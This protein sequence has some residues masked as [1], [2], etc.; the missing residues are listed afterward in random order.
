MF[1]V[2]LLADDPFTTYQWG[3]VTPLLQLDHVYHRSSVRGGPLSAEVSASGPENALWETLNWL[4]RPIE[5]RNEHGQLVW[6]GLVN[7]VRLTWAGLTIGATLDT[8]SNRI[9]VAYSYTDANGGSVRGTTAWAVNQSSIDRYGTKERLLSLGEGQAAGAL[10]RRTEELTNYASPRGVPSFGG[11]DLGATLLCVGWYETLTWQI[12][13]RLEGRIEFGESSNAEHSLGWGLTSAHIGFA[14]EAIHHRFAS[15]GALA[16][17]D[18][19]IVTGSASNN[20]TFTIKSAT[21]RE[22]TTYTA[23]TISFDAADDINDSANGL[24]FVETDS[25]VNVAGSAAN[26]RY[27]FVNE[28]GAGHLATDEA[29][30]GTITTAAAGPNIT[31]S[32]G[33]KVEVTEAITAEVPGA[34]VTLSLIG[35]RIAQ[36]FVV[37]D[38]I[39][40]TQVSI[41][42]GKI[43]SPTDNFQCEIWSNVSSAPGASLQAISV[44]GADLL[45]DSQPWRWITFT[46]LALSAGTY[47]LVVR[48]SGTVDALNYYSL[49]MTD[50]ANGTC[51]A[52]NGAAW[53]AHPR[54]LYLPYRVWGTESSEAQITRIISD[55]GQFI[56][57]VDGVAT[58]INTNQYRDG[59]MTAYDEIEKLLDLGSSAGKRLLATVTPA[60]MLR[61][62]EEPAKST[63]GDRLQPDGT[64]RNI[65]SGR[66]QRGLLPTG[67]WLVVDG[68]PSSINA[69]LDLSPLFVDEAGW[70]ATDPDI[71]EIQP[72]AA[73]VDL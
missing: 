61:I 53:V 1:A 41:P 27:H 42:I 22:Q 15:L 24:G 57:G 62:Y 36:S 63:D 31:L 37:T 58:G 8:M 56:A 69:Q 28:A 71:F 54:A 16:V 19:V 35:V 70:R 14:A 12:F 55:A 33:H 52:W 43:G 46:G 67:E 65:A 3:I 32:A 11:G 50:V 66:R 60:R 44:A 26:S 23:T 45:A 49:G 9:A 59:D 51:L 4:R 18:K 48:R 6:W 47:W 7:E 20:R 30:T 39:T 34:S 73:T 21:T 64:L 29:L 38:A 13:N 2:K 25:F 17:G 10:A 68:V 40:V 72:K 5:I